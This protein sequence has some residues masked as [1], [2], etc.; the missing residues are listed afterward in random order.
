VAAVSR[1]SK[2]WATLVAYAEASPGTLLLPLTLPGGAAGFTDAAPQ[3]TDAGELGALAGADLLAQTPEI[4][5]WVQSL[6]PGK[7]L[8]LQN[9]AYLDGEGRWVGR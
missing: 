3:P 9:L 6:C 4:R 8:V 1:P 7:R 2:G 5:T